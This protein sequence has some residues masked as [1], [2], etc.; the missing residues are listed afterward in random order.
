MRR[1]VFFTILA[2][3]IASC[4]QTQPAPTGDVALS[5]VVTI[6]EKS[7]ELKISGNVI[8]SF[9]TYQEISQIDDVTTFQIG[10]GDF[11]WKFGASCQDEF[12]LVLVDGPNISSENEWDADVNKTLELQF[13]D[14]SS[15]KL[16]I[17]IRCEEN[18]LIHN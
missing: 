13:K 2:T 5:K 16:G 4:G 3:L 18:K 11:K 6:N 1:I 15:L 17:K 10:W 7:L 9:L 14:S 12:L 8:K